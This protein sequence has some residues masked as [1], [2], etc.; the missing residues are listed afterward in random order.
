MPQGRKARRQEIK[1]R[2]DRAERI[3]PQRETRPAATATRSCFS[4]NEK[5]TQAKRTWHCLTCTAPARH[6]VK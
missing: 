5:F 1:A 4:S 2:L 6:F 3:F